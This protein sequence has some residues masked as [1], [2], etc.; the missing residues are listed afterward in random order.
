ME[1]LSGDEVRKRFLDY[2]KKKN[3]AILPSA[4]IIPENDPS[5]LFT[6]AGM[7]PLVPYLLGEKHPMGRRLADI[8]KCIRLTDIDEVGDVTHLTFFE[9][10]G[11]WSLG[12]YFKKDSIKWSFKFLTSKE[13]GLG[14][15][16]DKIYVTVFAGDEDSPRDAESIE[17]WKQVYQNYG[18]NAKVFGEEKLSKNRDGLISSYRIFLLGKEDNWWPAGGKHLGPQG[19]D[20][21]IFYYWGKKKPDLLK[22]RPGYNDYNFWE[23]WNNVFMEYERRDGFYENLAQKNVDTGMGLERVCSVLKKTP[24]VYQSDIFKPIIKVLEYESRIKYGKDPF[25][26]RAMRIVADHIRTAVFIMG[27]DAGIRPSNVGHGYVLRRLIRRAI[28]YQS[29]L[30]IS[31]KTNGFIEKIARA[32]VENYGSLYEELGR[33]F[34]F[35]LEELKIEEKKFTSTLEKGLKIWEK[36][37]K[38]GEITGEEAF[39][40]FS[41]YGFPIELTEEL[42][43]EKGI[44][45][46]KKGFQDAFKEHQE[47]SRKGS[48]KRFKG[49]LIDASHETVKL[50]TATHLLQAALRRVLGNHVEQKGSNITS[51]RLRFD[52]SHGDKLTSEEK[53]K[54][55]E[56]VN[57][58]ITKKLEI[59]YSEMPFREAVQSEAL[60]FFKNR[61]EDR[62]KVYIIG[63]S[64]HPFSK[65]ICNGPHVKNTGEL[66]KFKI[67]KEE[68]VS[69]GVR[70]IKAMLE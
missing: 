17:I 70:R 34:N 42:A 31:Y 15:E 65:E 40:L 12:D 45:L 44:K 52:F 19:P 24:D 39:H 46:D 13:F 43:H 60:G 27:D 61:Y 3:H 33:N 47:I 56:I 67:I 26:T 54:I 29:Q 64:A 22:E 21:E 5:V 9:M 23:V 69:S 10:L 51:E 25:Q 16:P 41:T 4:S 58:A 20:T 50:H 35:I 2:F 59:K 62:V 49:G 7:Q 55:E 28:R 8:Q 32:V 48:E 1:K 11:N 68:A 14:M 6:T 38:N 37:A 63:E 36:I 57:S 18:I 30:G 66:G 53:I